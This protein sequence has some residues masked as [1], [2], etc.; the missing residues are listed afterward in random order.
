MMQFQQQARTID[1][2]KWKKWDERLSKKNQLPFSTAAITGTYFNTLYGDMQIINENNQLK[3]L[4][5]HH[6]NITGKLEYMDNNSFL[7]T[8]NHA[9]YGK[10]EAP[11]TV[12]NGKIMGIEIKA[13]DFVEYD[14]YY[15]MKKN[16]Q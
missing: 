12:K 14:A 2:F 9:G 8:W 11:L 6:P 7:L 10:F 3:V 4:L 1:E 15:F 13:S 16:G 5:S